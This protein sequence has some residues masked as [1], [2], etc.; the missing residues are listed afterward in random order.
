M[1][2][3]LNFFW[4]QAKLDGK[5]SAYGNDGKA[6]WNEGSVKNKGMEVYEVTLF[7]CF[8]PLPELLEHVTECNKLHFLSLNPQ[9]VTGQHIFVEWIN[10]VWSWSKNALPAGEKMRGTSW[11]QL[12]D[13]EFQIRKFELHS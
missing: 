8:L 9:T 3:W 2:W 12:R 1:E 11:S 10:G 4:D 13:S 7:R 5:V 6:T